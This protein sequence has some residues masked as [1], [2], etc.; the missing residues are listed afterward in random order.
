LFNASD[1]FKIRKMERKTVGP[2]TTIGVP[3]ERFG[4]G[5]YGSSATGCYL[6][7][8]AIEIATNILALGQRFILGCV[9]LI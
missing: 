8:A 1:Y 3:T 9:G 5:R 6:G 7:R 4:P 2:K